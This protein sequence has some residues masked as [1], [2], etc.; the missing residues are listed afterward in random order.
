MSLHDI[1]NMSAAIQEIARILT[2]GGHL[3]MAIVHPLNSA[4]SFPPSDR[5]DTMWP[6]VIDESYTRPRRYVTIRSREGSTMTYHGIHRPLQAYTEA[7]TDAGFAIDQLRE[8]SNADR[9]SKWHRVPVF[10]HIAAS[11]T[12]PM[13]HDTHAAR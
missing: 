11:R 2:P 10:L 6:Y 7:L 9:Q 12:R 13:H 4:G 1:D 3:V 5:D 8:L